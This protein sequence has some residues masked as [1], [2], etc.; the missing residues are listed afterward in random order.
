[1]I[2]SELFDLRE[3]CWILSTVEIMLVAWLALLAYE[4]N[5]IPVRRFLS[6]I[7]RPICEIAV[8][9][10]IVFGFVRTGATK[11]TNVLDRTGGLW[12][13]ARGEAEVQRE[14]V[15]LRDADPDEG[16]TNLVF[17]AYSVTP[18]NEVFAADWPESILPY[19]SRIE[20]HERQFSLTNA[21]C[22]VREYIVGL[23]Q[24][25]LCD[26]LALTN[27]HP[28]AAF[29]ALYGDSLAITFPG[30]PTIVNS[31]T[32][33]RLSVSTTADPV[34]VSVERSLRPPEF[35]P[36]DPGFAADP[37]AHVEGLAYDST[38]E[39]VATTG[40]GSFEL[41]TGDELVV[42]A[43]SISFGTPHA[44]AG[45]SLVF[46][47]FL[48][49]ESY[50]VSSQYP[51]DEPCLWEG[52][53]VG[54][55]SSFGCTCRPELSFGTDVSAFA[56]ITNTVEV[57]DGIA[58]AK[59][60][61]GQTL[62]WSNS[63]E[64]ARYW[65]SGGRS[66]F[67][68]NDGCSSCG[69]CASGDCDVFD[70]PSVG[71]V[72]FRISLGSPA[73]RLVSGFLWFDRDAVFQP[74]PSSF[75]LLKRP[76]AHVSDATDSGTRT[77][78][79]ADIGGRTLSLSPITGGV[80]IVVTFTSTGRNDR[81]WEITREGGAMRFRKFNAGGSLM[82]D[83]SYS[84]SGGTWTVADN[85]SGRED[86]TISTGKTLS[87]GN[88]Y[89][90]TVE[91]VSVCGPVT[92]SHVRVTSAVVGWGDDAVL[93]EV[94]RSEKCAGG[95]WKTS[96]ASYW[97][98]GGTRRNGQ[99]RM[100]WGDDRAWSWVDYDDDGREVFRLDQRD[101]SAAPDEWGPY[102]IG[103]L[104]SCDAFATVTDYAPS[105]GDSCHADDWD[106]PRTVSRYVVSDGTATLI[107]RTWTRYVRGVAANGWPTVSETTI[108]ACSQS[109]AIDDPG[110]AVSTVVRYDD[111]SSLVPYLMRGETISETDEDGVTETHSHTI[112][113]NSVVRTV[114]FRTKGAHEAKTRAVTERDLAYGLTLYEA[115]QLTAD[116]GVEFGW[117]R[118]TYDSRHRL[119]FTQ[120]DDGSSETNAYDCC[121]LLFRIDRNGA[122]TFY[123]STPETAHLYH[124]EEE[125]YL[126]QLP[127]GD[128]YYY[129]TGT[130]TAF[131]NSFRVTRHFL[132][133]F[134]KETNTVVR[135]SRNQEASAID[136][137]PSD[138]YEYAMTS[139]ESCPFGLPGVGEA[140]DARGLR[141][142]MRD[143]DSQLAHVTSSEEWLPE[144]SCPDV[145]VTNVSYRGGGSVTV[146]ASS[147]HVVTNRNL[148]V[149]G[150]DGTRRGYSVTESGDCGAVTNSETACDFLGRTILVQTPVSCV[151]N[152]YV[153]AS[154][155]VASSFDVASGIVAT[156]MY[157][158][159][160]EHVGVAS[161]GL[162]DE[163]WTRY[164]QSGGA[165]WR[166]DGQSL[167]HGTATNKTEESW[168]QLT[169]LSETLRSRTRRYVDGVLVE[170]GESSFD[171]VSLDLTETFVSA[172]G[173]TS[174]RKSRFGRVIEET[175]SAGTVWTYY[176]FY[177]WPFYAMRAMEGGVARD[178]WVRV[179]TENG[180]LGGEGECAGTSLQSVRWRQYGYDARGNR[181]AET[182]ELGEAVARVYDAE[183][184]V[185]SEDGDAYPL[186]L[187]YD[188]AGRR[189]SL[190]TTRYGEDWDETRWEF[191]AATGRCISKTFA[192]GSTITNT[193]TADGLLLR[194]A[195]PDGSWA[196]NVY[197]SNRRK[198]G[199][200]S[201]D[202]SCAYGLSLDSFGRTVAAYNAAA[203][204]AYSLANQGIATNETATV[205][206]L[207]LD[208]FRSVDPYGRIASL[209]RDGTSDEIVHDSSNGV[210][211]AVSNAEVSVVYAYTGDLL[212][213]GYDL[214]LAGG[215]RFTR[216]LIHSG[217]YLRENVYAVHNASP[218]ATN[219]FAYG[220]DY[221]HRP[222][223]RSG[224]T[225]A[226]NSRGEVTNAT[227]AANASA[228]AY[229]GIG[230]LS[231]S[232]VATG[233]LPAVATSYYAN[234][235]NQY[236]SIWSA[237]DD[238]WLEHSENGE[239]TRFGERGFLYDAKSRLVC[240]GVWV[241]DEERYYAGDFT[242]YDEL[243]S[244]EFVVS[245]RYDHL[246]RRVQ[247]ITPA[248]THT[249]FY[250]GWMLIKEVIANI[251]GTTDVIEYH[252][253]K[254][255]SGT[256]GGAG[257]VGGLLYLSISNSS[258]PNSSTRQ[259]YIPFYDAYGNVMGYWDA[260]G[261]VV[262]EYT[263]DAFGKLISSS[264]PMSDV[265]SFRYSTKY[266]DPE[267]GFYYYGYRFYSPE[268]K[269]WISRDPIGEEGGV[270]LYAMCGNNLISSFDVLG[271]RRMITG[272]F[273]H[274]KGIK[275]PKTARTEHLAN[276]IMMLR[277]K[278]NSRY[279]NKNGGAQFNVQIKDLVL[280]PI[281]AI[282]TEI[283][284]NSK[285]VFIIAH[286]YL[287]VNDVI[288]PGDTY[289]WNNTDKVEEGFFTGKKLGREMPLSQFGP[290]LDMRNVY[291]CYLQED[292]RQIKLSDGRIVSM[293][294]PNIDNSLSQLI[295]R[296]K[297]YTKH[298]K[299]DCTINISIYEGNWDDYIGGTAEG[300]KNWEEEKGKEKR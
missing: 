107:A 74:S 43:P 51:L 23:G 52:W 152:S 122:K 277:E 260:Q 200:A 13:V 27:G 149:Y 147:G 249:Y 286:G 201:S 258:T 191:D 66:D 17:T 193:W 190:R 159:M 114:V 91:T 167:A 291:A 41:A 296:L 118:H 115:T 232:S 229:D 254:D 102:S 206:A 295:D 290:K 9:V 95:T 168:V 110:N 270:N 284:S 94:E 108:R 263:Y 163:S 148:S 87:N 61:L 183:G 8:L 86:V 54:T 34:S 222:V 4:H 242:D 5:F 233:G 256:I 245:N 77:V 42:I 7:R 250:D 129:D 49:S 136:M 187:G 58:V 202:P 133:V 195:R 287:K 219:S 76:D 119:R 272:V 269:R 67:L 29:K 57:V 101:G 261:S 175:S 174:V 275:T 288:F 40:P 16:P 96:Y 97:D 224:D 47:S 176:D 218:V 196:E 280:T 247:K 292:V 239:V 225:F 278:M 22:P 160:G 240:A 113:S 257:G 112:L 282:R 79:C 299:T 143:W 44:Y 244:F 156:N 262:A 63:C 214:A 137:N 11:S 81:S 285:N 98:D 73:D 230:N 12:D 216:E 10:A 153:G 19:G 78:A 228:Y 155:R 123:C 227:I 109:A 38:N 194:E 267:T 26:T 99:L 297:E 165:W 169:G 15:H 192:D 80:R 45:E 182:N 59:V 142:V 289:V 140:V 33:R 273:I 205:G 208:I 210:V 82:S 130:H 30:L 154:S 134:G 172:T 62:V 241:F 31:A 251:N 234:S 248:A 71:S 166:I 151:S 226:Y 236:E 117:R 28:P 164:M 24:T 211:A 135:H 100:V 203:R 221:L 56:E 69:S 298:K 21:W 111:E 157:D 90:R 85:T 293:R 189:T 207:S 106:K 39:T 180:D 3:A 46:N 171:N 283:D 259:L 139:S 181:V 14:E 25:N 64:H 212:D 125:V 215:M 72:R 124:A 68:S 48:R 145:V 274:S 55:N 144:S 35:T 185:V 265:F 93:R 179:P 268:L 131:K 223:S 253:G 103:D 83:V 184:R 294:V 158:V 60:F 264:G 217:N 173:D 121:R 36:Y 178:F 204:Y 281:G 209:T 197:D 132:D 243:Y 92:G 2:S 279:K 161:C 65:P 138:T 266:F 116:P 146:R 84:S 105:A 162:L 37:F 213:A 120:Y 220:Y 246:D 20:L 1:M 126:A 188:S 75:S 252:W 276:D 238:A 237:D 199:L 104:P 89:S 231:E 177:G 141:T 271:Q 53:H 198:T 186:R 235:L 70:G 50:S 18:S 150:A 127:S 255:L 128:K 32:G 300:L 88:D 6:V 170:S